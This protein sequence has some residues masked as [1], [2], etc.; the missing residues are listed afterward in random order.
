MIGRNDLCWCG[1]GKKYK[2]CHLSEDLT[3]G[4]VPPTP[5]NPLIKSEEE[6]IGMRKAGAFNGQLM[7]YIRDFVKPGVSTESINQLVHKYTIDHGHIPATLNYHGF[8]KSCCISRNS[9]VCHGIPS[10]TEFLAEGDIVNVDLTTIVDGFF[11]DQSETFILGNC[12]PEALQLVE[13]TALAT[14]AAIKAIK[15]GLKLSI[16]GDTVDPIVKAAG[17][18]V[19]RSYTGHGIGRE[20]H[21]NITVL[22]HKN[23][24]NNAILL[25]AGMTFT[26]EP[27]VNQGTF[28]VFTDKTDDW[29][30]WTRDKKLSAQFEHT[31]LVTETGCEVLTL[32]PSQRKSGQ[33]ITVN[34]VR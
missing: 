14:E 18:S 32:T 24:E 33:I 16:V 11:G 4:F 2:R 15:P 13:V 12:S 10:E 30:V 7:E 31:I 20:F 27:M 5:K 19:V 26:I 25:E 17:F 29:T 34:Y 23:T 22:H 9:V 8:P 21:E 3:T 28:G 6:I 1:S